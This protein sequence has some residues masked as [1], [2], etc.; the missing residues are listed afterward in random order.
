MLFATMIGADL[1][2]AIP[3]E[4]LAAAENR[5][6]ERLTATLLGDTQPEVPAEVR[7]R[8]DEEAHRVVDQARAMIVG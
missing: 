5:V 1:D 8:A 3:A 6:G 2:D 7:E 4:W